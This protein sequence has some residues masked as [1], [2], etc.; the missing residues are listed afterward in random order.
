MKYVL[1]IDG[2]G[3]KSHLAL[4]DENGKLVN[5]LAFGTLNHEGMAGS[6]EQLRTTFAEVVQKLLKDSNVS[7]DDLAYGVF[8]LAGVD[9]NTQHELITGFVKEAGVQR[10]ILS[11]D[12]YLGVPAG[13]PGGVG[14]C[15]INGTGSTIAAIDYSGNTMQ[16]GGL[17]YASDECGGGSWFGRQAL[18]AVF[19]ALFKKAQPTLMTEMIFNEIGVTR[20]ED[21]IEKLMG[22]LHFTQIRPNRFNPFVFAA[23]DKGD[24][25]AIA[26]LAR[27]TE[28]FAG[29]IAYLAEEMDFENKPI[30]VVFA[31]SVFVK[32][33]VKLLQHMVAKRTVEMLGG[34]AVSFA[35]I[36]TVPVTGAVLWAAQKAGF[37]FKAESVKEEIAKALN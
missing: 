10:F 19:N 13:C 28:H 31:G 14:M 17:G 6:F 35:E 9:T 24:E 20:K 1:G 8:G 11:N 29:T 37:D 21:Y 26:I 16:I 2:G 32:E 12:A 34:R 36:D 15:A 3:T 4:F 22:N 7:F 18:R 23:A 33:K 5:F 30:H 27:S 25:A